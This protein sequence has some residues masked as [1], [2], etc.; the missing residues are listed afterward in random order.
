MLRWN[1]GEVTVTAVLES[2]YSF[3]CNTLL[4]DS[5]PEEVLEI[6][7]ATAGRFAGPAGELTLAVQALLVRTPDRKIVVDTCMGNDKARTGG[8]GHMLSTDLLQRM[9][10]EGFGRD[11]V[12]TVLC[13]HLHIDHVGWNTMLENGRWVPTFPKARYLIGRA[14]FEHARQQTSGDDPAIFA[15][16]VMPVFEAGLAD[17]VETT[18]SVCDQVRLIP[19]H[20]H[21]PGHVSVL[22]ESQGQRGMITGDIMHNPVQMARPDWGAFVDYDRTASEATRRQVLEDVAGQ[23][24]LVIGTHFPAPTAGRVVRDGAAYRLEPLAP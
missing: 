24:V 10:S 23:P 15:D 11:D 8:A 1:I 17:L 6:G 18:H 14:E 12:D 20:G 22:I 2:E 7:W 3:P 9:A 16:S 13:T 21:T 5:T 4:P 19:T